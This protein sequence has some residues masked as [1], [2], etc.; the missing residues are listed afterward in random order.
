MRYRE[1]ARRLRKLGCSE[2]ERRGKGS[3]RMWISRVTG[4]G[5]ILPYSGSKDLKIRTLRKAVGQL[6]LDW[7]EFMG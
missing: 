2:I 4:K 3:H 6:G 7:Q 1:V 5:T